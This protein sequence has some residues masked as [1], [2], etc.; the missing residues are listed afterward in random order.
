[1][2][3][4]YPFFIRTII[5][6]ILFFVLF[7]YSNILS[8]ADT[9]TVQILNS[10]VLN[11]LN[12][13]GHDLKKLIGQ[14]KLQH[15][16]AIMYCDTAIIDEFSNVDAR[17]HVII[18]KGDSITMTGNTLYYQSKEKFATMRGNVKLKDR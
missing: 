5:S 10:D 1:M 18:Y 9:S 15:K 6:P 4:S 14:V 3:V 17:G 13:N 7:L 11:I 8:A 12:E 2:I 16:D